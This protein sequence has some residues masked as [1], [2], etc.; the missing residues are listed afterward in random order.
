M[1]EKAMRNEAIKQ[2]ITEK[3]TYQSVGGIFNIS[4]QRVHQIIAK[5]TSPYQLSEKRKEQ[6]KKYNIKNREILADKRYKKR[7]KYKIMVL[8]HYGDEVLECA[9]CG[10]KNIDCLEIDHI[11]N[12]GARE[13]RKLFGSQG[14]SG[15]SFYLWLIRNDFPKG[16]Q[17][18]C[19]NCNWLKYLK[20]KRSKRKVI[21]SLE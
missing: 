8:Q 10:I 19:K 1:K 9:K 13:R 4:R 18:L 2:L 20:Y 17:V 21:H 15:T 16:Y 3:K 5:Y 14:G 12:Q 11:N 6:K 7:S